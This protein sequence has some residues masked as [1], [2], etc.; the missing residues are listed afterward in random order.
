MGRIKGTIVAELVQAL[1]ARQEQAHEVLPERLRSYL[2]REMLAT[3]WFDETDYRDL[4]IALS[5]LLPA[6]GMDAFES[7]G[8]EG[9]KTDYRGIYQSLVQHGDPAGTLKSWERIWR[10]H[11]D[12]G[13]IEVQLADSHRAVVE[14]RDYCLPSR[15]ICRSNRGHLWQTLAEGGAQDI[16]VQEVCCRA[17]GDPVCRWEAEWT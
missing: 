15:E 6:A 10:L 17:L 2:G 7:L 11:H 12:S 5:R 4:L 8:R 14:L 3:Q 13:E 9:A 16:R 1:R